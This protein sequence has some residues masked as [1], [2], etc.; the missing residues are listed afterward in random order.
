[1]IR[2]STIAVLVSALLVVLPF[3][4]QEQQQEQQ[5]KQES[6]RKIEIPRSGPD[7][8]ARRDFMRTKLMFAQ[9][10]LEGLTTGD[11]D[12][13]EHG[14]REIRMVTEGAEWVQIDDDRYRKLTEEFKT[15]AKY[16]AEAAESG[17]IEA[18]ALRYYQMSTS[19]IDC[20]KHIRVANYDL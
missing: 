17:N 5:Q 18:T 6:D 19:C 7:A 1:M 3:H 13:I 4:L 8:V 10:I 14:V 20:H 12:L 2:L 9:N 16:L 15:A 11:L